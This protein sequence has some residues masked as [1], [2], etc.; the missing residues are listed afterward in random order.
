M[1]VT[2]SESVNSLTYDSPSMRQEVS[3]KNQIMIA[4]VHRLTCFLE[5]MCCRS[6]RGFSNSLP[7]Q[8]RH[9]NAFRAAVFSLLWLLDFF[10]SS[11]CCASLSEEPSASSAEAAAP[12]VG[13]AIVAAAVGG[14][15]VAGVAGFNHTLHG[16]RANVRPTRHRL[17]S[18]VALRPTQ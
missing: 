18:T 9:F 2:F 12:P 10:L 17:L 7:S 11:L 13:G 3:D 1:M 6:I 14:G 8:T 16:M 5:A 15:I 4:P